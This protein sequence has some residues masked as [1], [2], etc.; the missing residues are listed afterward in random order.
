M[1]IKKNT[2]ARRVAARLIEMAMR[3][4][5][6]G[7]YVQTAYKR[8]HSDGM[9]FALAMCGECSEDQATRITRNIRSFV[10]GPKG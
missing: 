2:H 6:L 3:E 8:G 5:K 10:Y 1:K 9:L 7:N 4:I